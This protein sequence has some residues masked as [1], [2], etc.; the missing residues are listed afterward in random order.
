MGEESPQ[1]P[2][3]FEQL[4][5]RAWA[6]PAFRDELKASPKDTIQREL[7]VSLP[8][9]VEVEVLQESPT[10]IYLVIPPAPPGVDSRELSDD[11]LSAVA[12]GTMLLFYQATSK[13]GAGQSYIGTSHGG[14]LVSPSGRVGMSI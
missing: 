6:D 13:F 3:K 8:A 7:G 5:A 14:A 11:E 4:I 2:G 10:K 12:G 1:G 9:D